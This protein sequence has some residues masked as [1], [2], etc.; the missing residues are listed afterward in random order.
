MK[1]LEGSLKAARSGRGSGQEPAAGRVP[2][3]GG[4]PRK[5][6][7]GRAAKTAKRKA[8]PKKTGAASNRSRRA[9]TGG[10]RELQKLSKADLYQRA[11]ELEVPGRSKMSREDLID[12]LA[13]AGRRLK[14]SAA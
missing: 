6:A 4:P 12:A 3:P 14:K 9:A 2:V 1:V 7:A 11:T 13:G 5:A 8:P 10:K